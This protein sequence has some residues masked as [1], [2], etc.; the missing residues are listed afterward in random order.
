[1]GLTSGTTAT[2]A[3][4]QKYG[5]LGQAAHRQVELYCGWGMW[6]IVLSRLKAPAEAFGLGDFDWLKRFSVGF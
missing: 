4:I 2:K 1:M 6:Y 5:N 3:L